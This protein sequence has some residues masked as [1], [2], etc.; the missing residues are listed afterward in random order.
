M[1]TQSTGV[2]DKAAEAKNK[3][4]ETA[5]N[6]TQQSQQAA[7]NA[8]EQARNVAGEATSQ[9]RQVTDQAKQDAAQL[10]QQAAEQARNMFDDATSQMKD[11]AS[12]E[13]KKAGFFIRNLSDQLQA[14]AEGRTE[15]AGDAGEWVGHAAQKLST[16]A[17][18]LDEDGIEGVAQELSSFARTKPETFLALAGAGGFLAGR[19][20]RGGQAAQQEADSNPQPAYSTTG[21]E[22]D[23]DTTAYVQS[24]GAL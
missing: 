18:R 15:D 19:F 7:H 5:Q 8:T 22:P 9:A 4:A 2:K 1:S 12:T 3:A 16:F 23:V 10:A 20:L 14:L 11:H 13:A 6:A 24:G 17:Q 21:M